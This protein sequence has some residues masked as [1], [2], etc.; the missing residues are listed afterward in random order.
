M[1][2]MR[3]VAVLLIQ[4]FYLIRHPLALLFREGV[5]GTC[6]FFLGQVSSVPQELSTFGL[7]THTRTQGQPQQH[8]VFLGALIFYVQARWP[9]CFCDLFSATWFPIMRSPLLCKARIILRRDLI[10]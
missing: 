3:T 10:Q 5:Q 4:V 9:S 7:S 6:M 1:D 2:K 8:G